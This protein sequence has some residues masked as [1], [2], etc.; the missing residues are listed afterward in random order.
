[1]NGTV[2]ASSTA[3]LLEQP[4]SGNQQG[5]DRASRKTVEILTRESD[6]TLVEQLVAR[7]KRRIDERMLKPGAKLPSIRMLAEREGVSRFTV[8]EAYD[9][10]V[11]QGMIESRRG[12]GFF[13]KE[14]VAKLNAKQLAV[15]QHNTMDTVWL[16]RNMF[17]EVGPHHMPGT[18]TVPPEWLDAELIAHAMRAYARG[19]G[20]SL[21]SYG[22]PQGW[23]PLREQ[24]TIKLAELEI[25]AA[26]QQIVT[27]AGITQAL[28]MVA[29]QLAR[30]GDTVLVDDPGWF[31]L[32]ASLNA[33]GLK[34]VGVPHTH[35]GPDINALARVC[36]THKPKLYVINSV[37]HNPTGHSLSAAKAFQILRLAEQ[38][39]FHIVEDDVYCDFHPGAHVQPATRL[40]SL[41]QLKRVIY[42]GSF[43]KTLAANL[44][45]GFIAAD[46]GLASELTD[47]KMLL[48]LTT[49]EMGERIVQKVLSEGHYRK[50]VERLRAKLE[51]RRGATLK[52]LEGAGVRFNNLSPCGLFLWGDLGVNSEAVANAGAEAGFVF[53]PGS[54]FS[55]GQVYSTMMRFNAATSSH[56]QMLRFLAQALDRA[57]K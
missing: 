22:T 23:L 20:S 21:L 9:R 12:S 40:A 16:L 54:L 3:Q 44:R 14:R 6:E 37:L 15:P 26:P 1:M 52:L 38:H 11:G 7:F 13:V 46:V 49:P 36:E 57:G 48:S 18:G 5:G 47:Q 39:D 17:R 8:V 10:L 51:P 25:D 24:L 33:Q 56:P 29:R 43:A 55:P 34:I 31:V 50:H 53:A 41:D 32:F 30:P 45:V 2:M 19:D 28:T 42:L 35:D 27:T 4:L